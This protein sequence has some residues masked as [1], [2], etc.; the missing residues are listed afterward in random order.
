MPLERRLKLGLCL[1]LFMLAA[2]AFAA[3]WPAFEKDNARGAVTDDS[4]GATLKAAWVHRAGFPPSPGFTDIVNVGSQPGVTHGITFDFVFHPVI[5]GGRVYYGSSTE[6]CVVCLDA[7][8]GERL[9]TFYA[10]GPVRLAPTLNAGRLYLGADDGR[11]Y[12][13]DADTG[14]TVW[15]FDA[16]P[17]QR[18]IVANG[19]V[20]SQW[21]VR[22]GVTIVEDTAYFAAGIFPARG[23]VSLYAVN[24][25]TGEPVWKR[26][27]TY[28][29]QGHILATDK[30]LFVPTGRACPAQFDRADGTPLA[31]ESYARREGGG[32]FAGLIDD[33]VVYGPSEYGIIHVR[34]S[35]QGPPPGRGVYPLSWRI[36]GL[37]AGIRGVRLLAE[38]DAM[39]LL[40]EHDLLALDKAAFVQLLTGSATERLERNSK[41]FFY[42][43]GV[44]VKDDRFLIEQLPEATHWKQDVEPATALLKAGELLFVGGDG[45]VEAR[46]ADTRERAWQ[47]AVQGKAYGLAAANGALY[48]STDRGLVYCFR[49]DGAGAAEP[50]EERDMGY[51]W[52]T[53]ERDAFREAARAVIDRCRTPRGFCF[54]LGSGSGRLAYE[55]AAASDLSVVGVESDAQAVHAS[56]QALR[57]AGVYGGRVVIHHVEGDKLPYADG[58]ANLVTSETAMANGELPWADDAGRLLQPYNGVLSKPTPAMAGEYA[59]VVSEAV[60]PEGAGEWTHLFADAAN[61]SCSGDAM[62]KGTDYNLQ[63]FGPPGPGKMTDRHHNG[64]GPLFKDG[65]L[66]VIGLNHVTTVDAY[67]GTILWEADLPHSARLG[68]GYEGGSACVDGE[69]FY[70]AARNACHVF[71]PVTGR[72]LA[73]RTGPHEDLDWGYTAVV[74]G[75]LLGTNQ[76]PQ[77]T[78]EDYRQRDK[79]A[80]QFGMVGGSQVVSRCLFALDAATGERKWVHEPD[81]AVVLNS[82][83][84]V[85]DGVVYL[86]ESTAQKAVSKEDG[87]VPLTDFLSEGA[88]L[89][90]LDLATGRQ[91][92]SVPLDVHGEEI[93]YAQV[94]GGTLLVTSTYYG[95]DPEPGRGGKPERFVYYDLHGYSPADGEHLWKATIRGCEMDRAHNTNIQ[96][97]AIIGDRAYLSIRYVGKLNVVDLAT[98]EVTVDPGYK[99]ND[100]GCGVLSASRDALFFRNMSCESYDL[101]AREHV[102]ISSISRPSCWV[103]TIPAGGLVMVPEG[104]AG[105][106][107]G[108]ALQTSIVVAPSGGN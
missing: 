88:R 70:I 101:S 6:D 103:G 13:L 80:N 96:H 38:G 87:F 105:C 86:A 20:A 40:R 52:P 84:S 107:C 59:V 94:G 8:T 49:A 71:D 16:A 44:Q 77:A 29:A 67:N 56:R 34:V 5:A 43:S 25:A 72:E 78:F 3:D 22:T 33:M 1:C 45:Y 12:C 54:V 66:F 73:A 32:A 91:R 31:E 30:H 14:E 93:L 21:P 69:R 50:P 90:A 2:P 64:M 97:P 100:K 65:R 17:E 42:K 46:R 76:S 10:E 102:A 35:P 36:E 39:Y 82:S 19:Q 28:A 104:T 7:A 61:S 26:V 27:T 92:W 51:P 37:T 85:A 98:G 24:A 11:V 55:I 47:A 79:K 95:K 89:V 83:I 106:N 53:A 15:T 62:A 4:V 57:K 18:R 23:G 74:D 9:W 63:W 75:L 58:L 108:F 81:G 60:P 48:A 41:A 99:R 68:V